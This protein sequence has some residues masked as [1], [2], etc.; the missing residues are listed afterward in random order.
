MKRYR[1][2]LDP[3]LR[4]RRT[5]E[6]VARA[7]VLAAQTVVAAELEQLARREAAYAQVHNASGPRSAAEF[8]YEHA[9]AKALAAA[10]LD[11]REQVEQA[12]QRAEGARTTWTAAAARVG[13][14]ER[15]D[16]RQRA[17]HAVRSLREEELTVDD[18]VVARFGRAER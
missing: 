5:E 9:H 13:A 4:V 15:L 14:L 3:V 1:F 11:Q 17:E 8:L 10:L 7:A 12:E 16:E 2:R 18:L 6:D